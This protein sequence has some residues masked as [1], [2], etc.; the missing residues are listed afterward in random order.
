MS[1]NP[2][3]LL[4]EPSSSDI[5]HLLHQGLRLHFLKLCSEKVAIG[6]LEF[7]LVAAWMLGSSSACCV[8]DI[9]IFHQRQN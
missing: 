7:N 8:P 5:G 6:V 3:L 9:I 4:E 2:S 1:W